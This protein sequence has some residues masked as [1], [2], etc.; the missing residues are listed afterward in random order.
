MKISILRC[1]CRAD[2]PEYQSI[3][4]ADVDGYAALFQAY[5]LYAQIELIWAILLQLSRCSMQR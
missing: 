1:S 2:T 3:Y 4:Q 5:N